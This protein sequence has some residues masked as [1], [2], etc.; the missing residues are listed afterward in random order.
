MIG[1]HFTLVALPLAADRLTGSGL[2]VGLIVS[3]EVIATVLFGTAAGTFTDRRDPRPVMIASDLLRAGVLALLAFL[4]WQDV[5]PAAVLVIAAF[6]LGLLR[7]MHDGAESTLVARL[8][9]DELDVRSNARLT[10]SENIGLTVG[11]LAAG[12]ITTIGIWIAFGIDSLTFVVAAIALALVGRSARRR[13][14]LDPVDSEPA[15]PTPQFRTEFASA[16]RAIRAERVY[17]RSLILLAFINIAALPLGSQLVTL[18]K[19]QLH[20]SDFAIGALFALGGLS[21]ILAAPLVERG[22]SIRLS[23]VL[24]GGT[25]LSAGV[26]IVGLVP[27]VATVALA[28]VL[29]GFGLAAAMTHHSAL[30][31]RVFPA[32]MQGRV[33][34]TSRMLLWSTIPFGALAGGWLS[35]QVDPAAMWLACGICGLAAV[36]W[37]LLVGLARVRL[38]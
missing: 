17:F 31:Q 28:M 14:L 37:A 38:D 15:A 26:L 4:T 7:L 25:L 36:T 12:A 22:T 10:L 35:D 34:L 8:V 21:G 30:R 23:A 33:S 27:S 9:P 13:H 11:T 20:L 3:A 32:R 19:Q 6:A 16:F 5:E 29:A 18:A 24:L 2:L 1:D